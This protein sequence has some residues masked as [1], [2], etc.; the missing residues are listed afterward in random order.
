MKESL[1]MVFASRN[2]DAGHRRHKKREDTQLVRVASKTN[3]IFGVTRAEDWS[4]IT[5]NIANDLHERKK[6]KRFPL[7][8][9]LD[10]RYSR[11][12][13]VDLA[14]F[15]SPLNCDAVV[16]TIPYTLL[17]SLGGGH[18]NQKNFFGQNTLRSCLLSPWTLYSA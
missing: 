7:S 10:I 8:H 13:I 9:A 1:I 17:L 4:S 6:T 16:F 15:S 12:H 18:K 11:E 3:A 2:V 5:L 14:S